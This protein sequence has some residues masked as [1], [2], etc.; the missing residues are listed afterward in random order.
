MILLIIL[1]V[2]VHKLKIFCTYFCEFV[3]V[4]AA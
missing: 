2:F 3:H 4:E 1:Y